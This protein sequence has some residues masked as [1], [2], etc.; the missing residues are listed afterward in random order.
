M[1]EPAKFV[2]LGE[3]LVAAMSR[4]DLPAVL[5]RLHPDVELREPESLPYGGVRHGHA[6]FT[7]VLQIM[8]SLAELEILDHTVH[9]VDDGVIL[10]LEV[11]FTSRTTGA[12]IDTR[13]VEVDCVEQGLVCTMELFYKDTHALRAFFESDC[14]EVTSTGNSLN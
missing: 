12:T 4:G 6:G 14:A 7:E 8:V 11:R 1:T 3:A 10:I 9:A 2:E 5:E 13:V